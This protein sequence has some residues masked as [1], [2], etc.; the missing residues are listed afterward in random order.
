MKKKIL[1]LAL[2]II[3][4]VLMG[5]SSDSGKAPTKLVVPAQFSEEKIKPDGNLNEKIWKEIP[6][7]TIETENG[8]DVLMKS[9][10]SEENISFLLEWKDDTFDN[11]SKVWE[12]DGQEWNNDLE[13]D[14]IAILWDRD[15]SIAYFNLKGCQAIC[16]T[17]N[18]DNDLWYMA[19]NSRQ[20]KA[21]LW[22]WM[23]GIG[24]IYGF[25][26]DRSMDD[27]VDPTLMKAARKPD[28]GDPGFYKNGYKTPVQRIAPDRPTKKLVEGLT[29]S[30]TPYPTVDQMEDITSYKVF[31]AGDRIP[32]I[33]FEGPTTGSRGD[34]FA[35]GVY[36]EGKWT[37]EISRKLNTRQKG[38]IVFEPGSKPIYYMFGVAVFNHSEPPPIEHFPSPPVS[39][40]IDPN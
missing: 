19:T 38:D 18:S 27:A 5:C 1:T 22:F 10:Y 36:D 24:N 14:K 33:Y 13:Q 11:V 17:E 23:A 34:V 32:F 21:D 9:V 26:D 16:H 7:T 6:F 29:A 4:T 28:R 15:D 40:R 35:R 31:Q 37:L 20:E 39:L 30:D 8:P 12:F 25:A 3:V 2:M